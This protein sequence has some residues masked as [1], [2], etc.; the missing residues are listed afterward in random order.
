MIAQAE[1]FSVSLAPR[2][3]VL[4]GTAGLRPAIALRSSFSSSVIVLET[5][6]DFRDY[7]PALLGR[8]FLGVLGENLK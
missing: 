4:T 3:P 6:G 8:L 1:K 2:P 7:G 5:A